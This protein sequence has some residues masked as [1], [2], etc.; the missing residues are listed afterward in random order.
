MEDARRVKRNVNGTETWQVYGFGGEL[1][2]EYEADTA[3]S[4]PQKEYSYRNGQ[5]LVTAQPSANIHWL[6]A[7]QL[8]TPR[9]IF[10]STGS[11]GWDD[12][13]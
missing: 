4:N 2:A 12:A 5:L 1:L 6:M 3:A 8:G 13:A 9:M 7:D 10:D 11:L